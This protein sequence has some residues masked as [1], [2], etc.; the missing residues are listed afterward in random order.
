M[1]DQFELEVNLKYASTDAQAALQE[2]T[3][4]QKALEEAMAATDRTSEAFKNL[5]AQWV[6]AAKQQEILTQMVNKANEVAEQSGRIIES[7]A[8]SFGNLIE[9]LET[10]GR[11]YQDFQKN[12]AAANNEIAGLTPEQLSSPAGLTDAQLSGALAVYDADQVSFVRALREEEARRNEVVR[13]AEQAVAAAKAAQ[14]EYNATVE[15]AAYSQQLSEMTELEAATRRHQD[16]LSALAEAQRA[17]DEAGGEGG[18]SAE[19]IQ[20]LTAAFKESEQT[21]KGLASATRAVTEAEK[22]FTAAASEID[23]NRE[24]Q[25]L[26]SVEAATRQYERSLKELAAASREVEQ[27]GDNATP[28]QHAARTQA[29]IKARQSELDLEREISAEKAQQQQELE[30]QAAAEEAASQRRIDAN[31][32]LKAAQDNLN[33][34]GQTQGLDKYGRAQAD[35]ARQTKSV[36]DATRALEQAIDQYGAESEQATQ[37]T[38]HLA[39][40]TEKLAQVQTRAAGAAEGHQSSMLNMRYGLYDVSRSMAVVS[41]V[42]IGAGTAATM[43]FSNWESGMSSVIQTNIDKP[44]S[45]LEALEGQ[46]KDLA[47]QIPVTTEELQGLATLAGQLEVQGNIGDFVDTMAQLG[48][49]SDTLS[50]EEAAEQIAKLVNVMGGAEHIQAVSGIDDAY[51]GFATSLAQVGVT[52]AATDAEIMH[53]ASNL[54]LVASQAGWTA[55]EVLG[56]SAATASFGVPAERARSAMQDFVSVVNQGLG[57]VGVE[58]LQEM[59]NVMGI[60]VDEIEAMWDADP[61]GF[62]QKFLES[63]NAA[64]SA[65]ANY[66][67]LLSQMGI[68][69]KR[70]IPVLSTMAANVGFVEHSLGEAAKGMAEYDDE[71]SMF[72]Q[73]MA[74]VTDDLAAMWQI[75]Q[76]EVLLAL[77]SV[78][79]ALAP[80]LKEIVQAAGEMLIS[81]REWAESDFGQEFITIATK[82]GAVVT[83][84]A[85]VVGGLAAA[86][87]AGIALKFAFAGTWMGTFMLRL[88][89][90]SA[91][92]QKTTANLTGARLAAQRFRIAL[93]AIAKSTGWLLA[94]DYGIRLLFDFRN[95]VYETANAVYG[96]AGAWHNWASFLVA[97][98]A[99]GMSGAVQTVQAAATAIVNTWNSVRALFGIPPV[100]APPI[101]AVFDAAVAGIQS[102]L[103]SSMANWS[104]GMD[105]LADWAGVGGG[106]GDALGSGLQESL[107]D[108]E[109]QQFLD[110]LD[111]E[112]YEDIGND[113]GDALGGGVGDGLG[114]GAKKGADDAKKELRLLTDYA[115]DLQSVFSRAF[116]LRFGV[117]LSRDDISSAFHNMRDAISDAEK[118]VRDIRQA[119]RDL[120][121][122]LRQT[123]A[124]ISQT[125]YFLSVAIEYGDTLRAQQLEAEL[126]KLQAERAKQQNEL[127]DKTKE[128]AEAEDEASRSLTGNSK[129]A[130]A[131]RKTMSDL[132]STYASH[133]ETL[134]ASG[135][136]QRD[137]A[138]EAERLKQEFISQALAMGYSEKEVMKYAAAFDDMA[139]I[140]AHIPRNVTIEFDGNPALTAIREFVAQANEEL[141]N[142]NADIGGG[143]G[144]SPNGG[145]GGPTAPVG[146]GP[147]AP[148]DNS[149]LKKALDERIA[150]HRHYRARDEAIE[151]ARNA[152]IER[153]RKRHIAEIEKI[154]FGDGLGEILDLLNPFEETGGFSIWDILFPKGNTFAPLMNIPGLIPMLIGEATRGGREFSKNFGATI[155]SQ[156]PPEVTKLGTSIPPTFRKSGRDSSDGFNQEMNHG[157]ANLTGQLLTKGR[158]G[159]L[160]YRKGIVAT[161]G[162]TGTQLTSRVVT[163]LNNA[164]TRVN[165]AGRNNGASFK[166]GIQAT[167][168]SGLQSNA[169]TRTYSALNAARSRANQAGRNVGAQFAA[170]VRATLANSLANAAR[171]AGTIAGNAMLAAMRTAI[172]GKSIGQ[173]AGTTIKAGSKIRMANLYTG[174][175]T[176]KGGVYEPANVQ[177]HKGEYV[178]PQS[179]VNQRTGLPNANALGLIHQGVRSGGSGGGVGGRSRGMMVVEL[180]AADRRA[181]A[182]KAPVIVNVGEERVARANDAASLSRAKRGTK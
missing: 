104:R 160:E 182:S 64:E 125:E 135:M 181:I 175:Y 144:P 69:G 30:A 74:E 162:T 117:S 159:G 92:A 163:A 87:A 26:S 77:E 89:G 25:G 41:G 97:Q 168:V 129:A 119:I 147:S 28:E 43:A 10:A 139:V 115:S 176:G 123:A 128:L 138:R 19:Q 94:I 130:I 105:E 52:T 88:L 95:T 54:G 39:T 13:Q 16:A 180:S 174:G 109:L 166:S 66:T 42:L 106:I 155:N 153:E 24:L 31:E 45:E 96:L 85:L 179:M 47:G 110:L 91:A 146:G 120:R 76:N 151:R 44:T 8:A 21:R 122:D 57:G 90:V 107:L 173:I 58:R 50:A 70:A 103:A 36:A 100:V 140:I 3:N 75:L 136:S 34:A 79:T 51:R 38:N 149:D 170:G 111:E 35:V 113:I 157:M 29:M 37:A 121:A 124:S 150:L 40:E 27:A 108:V 80:A 48:T 165:Q 12:A 145:G 14:Q 46:L 131:N 148:V 154:A 127:S 9:A 6:D 102:N 63:L 81:F 167:M 112:D 137:L 65:G 126:A 171:S 133:L 164:R 62:F 72:N 98:I 4:H 116:D 17:Y 178:L 114:K 67:T 82:I 86:A 11:A 132:V 156:I 15:S 60:T 78:G 2:L 118:K 18:A 161:G 141:A 158:D 32:R 83:V 22:Q 1:S 169:T 142:L 49:L 101:T 59:A 152:A 68:E 99:Q 7:Q 23:W 55:D 33:Y 143:G 61:M 73:R 172:R 84:L 71:M 5:Q 20:T 134:A 93:V 56:L 53:T 177:V